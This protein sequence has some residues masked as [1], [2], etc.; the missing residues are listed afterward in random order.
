M[1]SFLYDGQHLNHLVVFAV[2]HPMRRHNNFPNRQLPSIWY[3]SV[4]GWIRANQLQPMSN[5]PTT[6]SA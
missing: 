6:P 1:A 5:T 2:E 4:E 3:D